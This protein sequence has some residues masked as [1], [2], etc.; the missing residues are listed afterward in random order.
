MGFDNYEIEQ[1]EKE[2]WRKAVG[3]K[4]KTRETNIALA[5][6]DYSVE[7]ITRKMGVVKGYFIW[8]CSSH[9]QPYT[10]CKVGKGQAEINRLRNKLKSINDI[11]K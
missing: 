1:I 3:V 2:N 10:T 6:R 9:H 5:Q 8:W 11:V 4:A 7:C